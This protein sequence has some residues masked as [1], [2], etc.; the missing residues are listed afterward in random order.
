VLAQK[1]GQQ[2]FRLVRRDHL[3]VL[4]FEYPEKK[5][6][7]NTRVRRTQKANTG[8]GADEAGYI[9]TVGISHAV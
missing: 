8:F 6:D 7:K 5:R 9:L 2:A 1:I 3:P 4:F